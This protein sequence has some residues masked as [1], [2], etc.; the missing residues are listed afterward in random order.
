MTSSTTTDLVAWLREQIAERA[1]WA[2]AAEQAATDSDGYQWKRMASTAIDAG[3]CLIQTDHADIGRFVEDNSPRTALAQCEAHT[4]LLDVVDDQRDSVYGE[5]G[6][7]L[8]DEWARVV[9]LLAL[10]YQHRPG[11]RQEWR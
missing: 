2:H 6:E 4:A 5:P 3:Y 11:Y 9:R 8:P 10:A 1:R 7:F